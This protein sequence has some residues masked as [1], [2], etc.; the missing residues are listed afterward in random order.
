MLHALFLLFFA[1]SAISSPVTKN[2]A[3]N[4]VLGTSDPE[5]LKRMA[6]NPQQWWTERESHL[7]E[8]GRLKR[9]PESIDLFIKQTKQ[10]C[11]DLMTDF[12]LTNEWFCDL[13]AF[14]KYITNAPKTSTAYLQ[15]NFA[16]SYANLC[17][18]IL[19]ET[20][21]GA[22]GNHYLFL[23]S[24]AAFEEYLSKK[25]PPSDGYKRFLDEYM[26]WTYTQNG[27][28]SMIDYLIVLS[29]N[30]HLG[31]LCADVSVRDDFSH[32]VV[33]TGHTGSWQR[34]SSQAMDCA[35][36]FRGFQN[37]GLSLGYYVKQCFTTHN[38]RNIIELAQKVLIAFLNLHEGIFSHQFTQGIIHQ[39]PLCL[40]DQTLFALIP[41]FIDTSASIETM[42][43]HVQEASPGD[44]GLGP[45]LHEWGEK[46]LGSTSRYY[47]MLA[48]HHAQ[49][50]ASVYS[51]TY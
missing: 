32:G 24:P 28:F 17:D 40:A 39:K 44:V 38:T 33:F 51:I 46:Y 9:Y 25:R 15:E 29:R 42:P 4:A 49:T 7:F 45:M 1:I 30:F 12:G 21:N 31:A 36:L 23:E 47:K 10:R 19:S 37:R 3:L 35:Y 11:K 18:H 22:K 8:R 2:Q 41:F 27:S 13:E 5:E 26:L 14:E 34:D 20:T 50:T 43:S 6:D 16:F 48:R